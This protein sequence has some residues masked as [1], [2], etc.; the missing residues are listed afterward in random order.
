MDADRHNSLPPLPKLRGR[1][2]A[3]RGLF[4]Y[5]P[6]PLPSFRRGKGELGEGLGPH[7][8]LPWE[9]RGVGEVRFKKGTLER[10]EAGGLRARIRGKSRIPSF[11][12]RA[13]K[14]LSR[15]SASMS[16]EGRQSLGTRESGQFC[17]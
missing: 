11:P 7:S 3:F 14:C 10:R 6:L 5:R 13:W 9:G 2:E 17:F 8:P 4:F 16:K 15:G 1:G 12:G